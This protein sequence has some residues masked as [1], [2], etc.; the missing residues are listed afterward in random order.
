MGA[1]AASLRQ[2]CPVCQ[3]AT[4]SKTCET[5]GADVCEVCADHG[6]VKP[7]ADHD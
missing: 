4:A 5:C 3:A 6:A 7:G 1:T 2:W